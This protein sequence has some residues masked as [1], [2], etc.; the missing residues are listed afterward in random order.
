MN[1]IYRPILVNNNIINRYY[2]KS[3]PQLSPQN[4]INV[5]IYL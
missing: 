5:Y 3:F 2:Y 4:P 1:L